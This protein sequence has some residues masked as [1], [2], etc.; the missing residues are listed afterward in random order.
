MVYWNRNNKEKGGRR[1]KRIAVIFAVML[2][3][4]LWVAVAA[5]AEP[6]PAAPVCPHETW[7]VVHETP[8]SCTEDG[9]TEKICLACGETAK[10]TVPALGHEWEDATV[11]T[12]ASCTEKGETSAV[13]ARCGDTV[14]EAIPALGHDF[15]ETESPAS[16][17]EEGEIDMICTRCGETVRE[18][19]PALG[20]DFGEP[21][22][23]PASCT[24]AGKTVT[25]CLR[26]GETVKETIPA[27]GH[28]FGE[29]A[30]IPADCTKEGASE[31][32]CARCGDT[33]RETILALGHDFGEPTV[34][35]ATCAKEG[36]TVAVCKRCGETVREPLPKA[37]HQ[38]GDWQTEKA[39][40]WRE[41]GS[42]F[43]VCAVCG[44]RK[45]R[46]TEPLQ[47]RSAKDCPSGDADMDGVVTAADAR[48]IL[49]LS[50]AYDDGLDAEQ[51][52]KADF[53]G[54]D[55]VTASDARLALRVSVGLPAYEPEKPKIP[56]LAEGYTWKGKTAK[57]YDLAE[58]NGVT[59]VVSPYGYTLI[60]NKTYSLP[61]SYAPGDLTEA[62]AAAF[63]KMQQAAWKDGID[64]YI[65]SGYRSYST[66]QRIYNNY[67]ARDGKAVADTY[68]ARPGHSEH[69][70]GLAMDLNS[71]Y[72]S[73]A[74]TAEGR[75]LA[76][77]AYKYGFIIRYQKNKQAITGYVYEPW[78]VRYLG[79]ALAADVYQSGLCLEEYFGI[80]S[81]YS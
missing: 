51:R 47:H 37:A 17:T 77:N 26:C 78:H 61:A 79:E 35:P 14:T 13:C 5:A 52:K 65:V 81:S 63:R 31:T 6:E 27:L 46:K 8:P 18:T 30:V 73:F 2:A 34:T 58:K 43:C 56:Q 74:Y 22:T 71:L 16:C 12:P 80:T 50:V 48:L 28:D 21:T 44:D 64:L 20:H 45:E 15:E 25:V 66:Q 1:M 70:S 54:K 69:Q 75:W 32:V 60:A 10:E 53:D 67:C 23:I 36:E 59:Y 76:A 57:G 19:I 62:C 29:P 41:G 55:G 39:P 33:V 72:A 38:Y 40:T 9:L 68:S 7:Q 3:L 4:T 24:G 49:R 11:V 42:E